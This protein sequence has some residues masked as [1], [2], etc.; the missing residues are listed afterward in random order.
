MLKTTNLSSPPLLLQEEPSP[1]EFYVDR[2]EAETEVRDTL[3][4][5]LE[6]LGHHDVEKVLQI[7][8]NPLELF[9]VKAVTRCSSSMPGHKEAVIAVS[10]SPDGR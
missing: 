1:Y 6:R 2:M 7:V 3:E 4:A 5:T 9:K 8:Y 10:F